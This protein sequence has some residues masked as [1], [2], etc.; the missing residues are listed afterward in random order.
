MSKTTWNILGILTIVAGI[1]LFMLAPERYAALTPEQRPTFIAGGVLIL[2][3]LG[4]IAST[5][6]FPKSRPVTLR[7]LGAIG[8]ASCIFT[9]IEGAHQGNFS[10][11]P[12]TIGFWLPGSVYLVVKGKMT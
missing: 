1:L 5:C 4:A 7:I 6:F 10:R 9:L 11:F 8:I 2:A 12:V 3:V